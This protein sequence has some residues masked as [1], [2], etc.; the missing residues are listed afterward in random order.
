VLLT[1]SLSLSN[2]RNDDGD[3]KDRSS[4]SRTTAHCPPSSDFIF[5]LFFWRV[6]ARLINMLSAQKND[7]FEKKKMALISSAFFPIL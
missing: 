5:I 1:P 7:F 4:L 2:C 6:L 3:E